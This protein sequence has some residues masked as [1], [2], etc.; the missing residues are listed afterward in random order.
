[1]A[2]S[3]WSRLVRRRRDGKVTDLQ[4]AL[5]DEAG[6]NVV[7]FLDWWPDMPPRRR[8]KRWADPEMSKSDKTRCRERP[9]FSGAASKRRRP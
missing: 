7:F 9:R 4:R 6:E 5:K 1:M 3:A 8:G 2:L